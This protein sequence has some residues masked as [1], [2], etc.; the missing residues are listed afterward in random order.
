MIFVLVA[1]FV[2]AISPAFACLLWTM[3]RLTEQ[4]RPLSGARDFLDGNPSVR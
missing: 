1:A 3:K 2:L 4:N